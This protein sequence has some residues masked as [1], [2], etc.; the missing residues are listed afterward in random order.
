MV[1][2]LLE[3]GLVPMTF[4][5]LKMT[6]I[7]RLVAWDGASLNGHVYRRESDVHIIEE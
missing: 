3:S 1:S 6:D 7:A 4:S 2:F 5:N